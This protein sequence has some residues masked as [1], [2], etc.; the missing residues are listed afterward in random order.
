MSYQRVKYRGIFVTATDTHVG[1][2]ALA[3]GLVGHFKSCG[4]NTGVMKPIATGAIECDSGQL[5]SQD[6]SMLINFS[7]AADPREWITPYCL[8]TSALPSIAARREGVVI[9]F[10]RIRDC[11]FKLVSSHDL[12]V[13]E[14]AGGIMTPVWET[15]VMADLIRFLEIPAIV[16]ARASRGTVNHTLLTIEGLKQRHVPVVGF[17]INRY[18]ARPHLSETT[19]AE[20]IS[21]LSGVPCL[22]LIPDLGETFPPSELMSAFE[23]SLNVS[24]FDEAFWQ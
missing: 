12:V 3:A 10:G 9:D 15:Q 22:G 13:V 7:G 5:I 19:S 16:V 24:E 1:K 20:L 11:F 17:F 4:I 6:A 2:T 14:G 23:K 18:P 21:S 8:A